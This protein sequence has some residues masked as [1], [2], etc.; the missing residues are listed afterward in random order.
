MPFSSNDWTL[1]NNDKLK[2]EDGLLLSP[3]VGDFYGIGIEI[4]AGFGPKGQLSWLH[5]F[6]IF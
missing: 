2:V 3:T 5:S 6:K 1:L 4:R